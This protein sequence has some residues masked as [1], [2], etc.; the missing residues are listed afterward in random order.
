M[1]ETGESG[2]GTE[3]SAVP[4]WTRRRPPLSLSVLAHSFT[5]LQVCRT[6]DLTVDEKGRCCPCQARNL[7]P[8]GP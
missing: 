4:D 1:S 5:G 2:E 3:A 7:T 6:E 8:S